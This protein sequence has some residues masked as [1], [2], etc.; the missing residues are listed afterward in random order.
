MQGYD[1]LIVIVNDLPDSDIRLALEKAQKWNKK[2]Y[3]VRTYNFSAEKNRDIY[4]SIQKTHLNLGKNQKSISFGTEKVKVYIVDTE[5]TIKFDFLS[6]QEDLSQEANSKSN[7][8]AM[9]MTM[10]GYSAKIIELKFQ[11]FS[12]RIKQLAV[13]SAVG[14]VVPIPGFSATVELGILIE[15]ALIGLQGFGLSKQSIQS[16]E[17]QCRFEMGSI[18]KDLSERISKQCPLLGILRNHLPASVKLVTTDDVKESSAFLVQ[19][20][21]TAILDELSVVAI[22]ESIEIGVKWL[23]P[24]IGFAVD[25]GISYYVTKHQ[26]Q[27]FLHQMKELAMFVSSRVHINEELN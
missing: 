20:C 6:L 22:S 16:L 25:A 7:H 5:N 24:F 3:L 19:S 9:L 14:G 15:E 2:V 18:E 27:S 17:E 11:M 8:E 21:G 12:N 10:T 26:L 4:Y 13:A 23:I 1:I